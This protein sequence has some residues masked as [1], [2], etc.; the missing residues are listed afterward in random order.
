MSLVLQ[1][2]FVLIVVFLALVVP[3]AF[4]FYESDAAAALANITSRATDLLLLSCAPP[5]QA[6]VSRPRHPLSRRP[7]DFIARSVIARG[8]D[9]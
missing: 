4:F 3:F 2:L 1:I 6:T 5:G 7:R 9:P 8:S